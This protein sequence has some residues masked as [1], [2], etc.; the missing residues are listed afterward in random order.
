[1]PN[2]NGLRGQ[3][4]MLTV[5]PMIA[6]SGKCQGAVVMQEWNVHRGNKSRCETKAVNMNLVSNF[7]KYQTEEH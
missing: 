7:L 3:E 2:A 5:R 6:L 1:M 4:V